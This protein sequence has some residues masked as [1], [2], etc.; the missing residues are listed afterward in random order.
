[1]M[2]LLASKN[3][4]NGLGLSSNQG[5][6]DVGLQSQG[7]YKRVNQ[8]YYQQLNNYDDNNSNSSKGHNSSY[9]IHS[10]KMTV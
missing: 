9:N 2:G 3:Q 7:G 4:L 10:G 1:M 5:R 6:Y 8:I